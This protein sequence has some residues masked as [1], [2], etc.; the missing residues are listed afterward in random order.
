M[1]TETKPKKFFFV[2]KILVH[3]NMSLSQ[4]G[5]CRKKPKLKSITP[6][7]KPHFLKCQQITKL[8]RDLILL[9][10]NKETSLIN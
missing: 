8:S 6:S 10:P 3:V 4:P 2:S 1:N 7:F 9:F 5:Y